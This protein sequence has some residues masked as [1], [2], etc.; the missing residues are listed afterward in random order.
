MAMTTHT[1]ALTAEQAE[2]L[3][4]LLEERG[5]SFHEVPYALFSGRGEN[6]SVTVY[7]KG[8]KVVVQ[9]KGS[10]DFVRFVLEPEILG[11]ARLGYEHV[12]N[13]RMFEPHFGIDE[14]GKGDFFGPL[15]IAG[16]YT[17][18]AIAR[19][20]LAGGVADSKRI[21]SDARIRQLAELVRSAPGVAWDVVVIPPPKYNQLMQKVGNLNR[22]LGWGHAR[23]IEN[24]CAK[25]P[26]CPRSLSDQFAR[27]PGVVRRA[28]LA[29]GREL[30][31]E[32][33]TKAES[34]IAVAA[35]SVLARE[36]FVEWMDRAATD[37]RQKMPKGASEAVVQAARQLIA[38]HGS[39]IL[40]E[41]A[42]T[43]FKTA[44]RLTE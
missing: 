40:N 17:D 9:G 31:V 20:L 34:D 30:E 15:V 10:E 14:S 7:T 25:K 13:P 18:E 2:C 32:Q 38:R 16:V 26:E 4:G 33:R 5:Y 35:A 36:K 21:G 27:D 28:L 43:H 23:V 12:H 6:V 42:K 37:Y 8:P 3:R 39:G 44:S 29:R 1:V 22:L 11:E 24:L 19:H 41:V